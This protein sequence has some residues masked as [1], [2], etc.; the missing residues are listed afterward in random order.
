MFKFL[1]LWA[2]NEFP[3]MGGGTFYEQF[4]E[5]GEMD[6]KVYTLHQYHGE[7]LVIAFAGT[8]T[9]EFRYEPYEIV[10]TLKRIDNA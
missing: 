10:K 6:S 9:K 8:I 3:E 2:V 5:I 7:K 4:A 1:L